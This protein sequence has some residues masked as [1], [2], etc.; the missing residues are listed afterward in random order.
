VSRPRCVKATRA[1]CYMESAAHAGGLIQS[2]DTG[3][4]SRAPRKRWRDR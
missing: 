2:T 4:A 3:A 1:G